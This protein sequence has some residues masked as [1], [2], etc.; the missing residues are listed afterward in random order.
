VLRTRWFLLAIG[1]LAAVVWWQRS[2]RAEREIHLIA[3]GYTGRVWILHNVPIG[4]PIAHENGARVYR[5]PNSGILRSQDDENVGWA[6]PPLYFYVS[7]DSLRRPLR[8]FDYSQVKDTTP[9]VSEDGV[10]VAYGANG[11]MSDQRLTCRLSYD[12]YSIGTKAQILGEK[13]D[14]EQRRLVDYAIAEHVC[15]PNR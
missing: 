2:G 8:S 5:I 9:T 7:A 1:C 12:S 3:A 14:E 4:A 10:F 11:E 6:E 15:S 13:D